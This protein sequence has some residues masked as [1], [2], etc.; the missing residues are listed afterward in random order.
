MPTLIPALPWLI[1]VIGLAL[2]LVAGGGAGWPYVV[3]WFVVL[4]ALLFLKP[5]RLADHKDRIRWAV[6]AAGLLV[7]PGLVFGGVYLLPAV[8]AWFLI[9]LSTPTNAPGS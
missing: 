7:V 1:A 4:G 3:G 9:E 8:L 5:I 6:I 2:P